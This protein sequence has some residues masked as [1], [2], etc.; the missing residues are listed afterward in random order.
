MDLLE[1]TAQVKQPYA[2]VDSPPV[3]SL[4]EMEPALDDELTDSTR[5][6]VK[7]IYEHWK[8]RRLRTNNKPLNPSLKVG[9][10]SLSVKMY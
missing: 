4:E 1:K 7:E 8:T 6:F 5:P 9:F 2:A 10:I 3:L